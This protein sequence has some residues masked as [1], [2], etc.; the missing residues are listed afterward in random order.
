MMIQDSDLARGDLP[1]MLGREAITAPKER[2]SCWL[3][4][5]CGPDDSEWLP[6]GVAHDLNG[7]SIGC[8]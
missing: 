3:A 1:S 8:D 7:I 2:I 5:N 4:N 6:C